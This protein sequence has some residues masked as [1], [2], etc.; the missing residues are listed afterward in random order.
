M[1]V[2]LK[3]QKIKDIKGSMNH[4]SENTVKICFLIGKLYNICRKFVGG[5]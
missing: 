2:E 5:K 4:V 1:E 3:V